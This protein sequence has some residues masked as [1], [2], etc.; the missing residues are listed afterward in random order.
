MTPERYQQVCQLYHAAL[1]LTPD[2][3]VAFFDG[4]CGSDEELRREV[5]S[6]LKAH[7]DAG[8]YFASPA[9]EVAARS[10][11]GQA[12]P[13]LAGQRLNHYQV[14]SMLGVGGMG[15]VYLAEDTRLGRK[16]ALK[17]LPAEFTRDADR[18]QRFGQEAR[19]ASALNHPNIITIHEIGQVDS[20]NYIVTEFV[21]GATLRQ[22]MTNGKLKIGAALDLAAQVAS[23]L[24]AA[25]AAGIVHRDIKPENVMVRPDGLVKVLDFGLAKLTELNRATD[26]RNAPTVDKSRT[27][28]GQVMGTPSYMSPEQARGVAVDARS[29]IFSLGVV[30]YEMI[31]GRPPFGGETSTDIVV[32]IV[33]Q[34][35]GPL[36]RYTPEAPSELERIVARALRKDRDERYQTASELLAD[37]KGLKRQLELDPASGHGKEATSQGDLPVVIKRESRQAVFRK[38]GILAAVFIVALGAFYFLRKPESRQPA[39]VA[40]PLTTDQGFEGMPSFSPD[41]NYVAFI[42]GGGEQQKDF[43]L[44]VKQIGGGPPLRLTSGPAVEEFPAWSPD[45]RSIA[46]V[47]TKGDKLDV[48]LI[49]PIGGPER[50]V[51]E[52]AADTSTYVFSFV[53]P[54]LSWSSDSKFIV[55][56]DRQSPEESPGLFLLSVST[57]E[58]R[59]LTSPPPP[60]LA[61]G[62]PA[63]SPDG[64]SLAFVRLI[65]FGHPQLFVLPLTEDYRP[66]AEARRINFSQPWVVNPVWSHDGQ[67]ILCSV[68]DQPWMAR[69]RLWRVPVSDPETRKP[70]ALVGE[71]AS[72]FAVSWQAHRLVYADWRA[73]HDIWRADI[74][75]LGRN[76]PVLKLISSTQT[77]YCPRYSP[78]GSKIAFASDRSGHT[79]IWVCNSDGSNP[80]QLTSLESFSEN[81]RWFPD[82][83]HIVFDSNKE[84]QVD[85]YALDTDSPVPRRLTDDLSDDKFPNIS[86]DGNW[87]YFASRRTGRFEIW[88]MPSNGGKPI[89]LTSDGGDVPLESADETIVY[90][91]KSVAETQN[92]VWKVSVSGGDEVRVLGPVS[93][94]SLSIAIVPQGVY[95][96][97]IGKL[98]YVGSKN[99]SLKFRGFASSDTETVADVRLNP[100]NG[101]SISPDGRY[102]L[103][104]LVDPDVSDLMVV[105]SFK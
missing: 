43:D 73:D 33:Q 26:E 97:E 41:G 15:E 91:S 47:R 103:M 6:M 85:V 76:S 77:D 11:S 59:R 60:S 61:D 13:S 69:P 37:L 89:Q 36:T 86:H 46:F 40:R 29:D 65:S 34:E 32:S 75:R 9:M 94:L 42:A 70:V 96:I 16:V 101:L 78:D 25:H 68:A 17:L 21:M 93:T 49:P 1:E 39:L 81:P 100:N 30:L 90:Y 3:R 92:E 20:T 12:M 52:V 5:E 28:P 80:L 8:N 7:E 105:D 27:E 87:I 51:A 22:Q 66:G 79:E 55:T 14:L 83:R 45:G 82:G 23:A 56:T 88:R 18:V 102:A 53:P 24:A 63:V 99:N 74:S 58:K 4:T 35:P 48:L 19:A 38:V 10:L 54:L 31:T 84:G 62:N 57:G 44:Y 104:T 98:L 64:R 71:N 2:R 50:K 72:Q 67:E 95:F